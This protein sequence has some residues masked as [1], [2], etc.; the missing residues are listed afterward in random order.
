MT[1][2]KHSLSWSPFHL[3]ETLSP[4]TE[5][6]QNAE[7]P[8][9]ANVVSEGAIVEV[10]L[11]CDAVKLRYHSFGELETDAN[12]PWPVAGAKRAT[13]L[14]LGPKIWTRGARNRN[15]P[16]EF[17]PTQICNSLRLEAASPESE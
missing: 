14:I 12:V 5:L 11:S 10:L 1:S 7:E 15:F 9:G 17:A 4:L 8:L 6:S 3:Q 2:S 13:A 16:P